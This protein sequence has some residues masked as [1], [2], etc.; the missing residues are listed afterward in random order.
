MKAVFTLTAY[1][2][3]ELAGSLAGAWE[4]LTYVA[5]GKRAPLPSISEANKCQ[6]LL[7]D[8]RLVRHSE[9]VFMRV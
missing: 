1:L 4:R 7:P 3:R 6:H 5:G 9:R 8:S 2:R